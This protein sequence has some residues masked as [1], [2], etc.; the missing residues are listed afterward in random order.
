MSNVILTEFNKLFVDTLN[1]SK[2]LAS[3]D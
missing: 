2:V 3:S 1:V